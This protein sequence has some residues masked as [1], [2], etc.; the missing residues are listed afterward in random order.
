MKNT[1]LFFM[2]LISAIVSMST[3]TL[4][5]ENNSTIGTIDTLMLARSVFQQ[6]HKN[7][8]R[9]IDTHQFNVQRWTDTTP[10][11]C[12]LAIN[13]YCITHYCLK[14]ENSALSDQV[15]Y[16]IAQI[17]TQQM[18]LKIKNKHNQYNN[19]L[20]ECTR[21]VPIKNSDEVEV[22]AAFYDKKDLIK[23]LNALRTYK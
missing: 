17:N 22:T 13:P 19:A 4:C 18:P 6:G 21:Y 3:N 8:K 11:R 2:V 7:I 1:F 14:Y 5:M 20:D 10:S 12:V 23:T 9:D 16:R 15:F